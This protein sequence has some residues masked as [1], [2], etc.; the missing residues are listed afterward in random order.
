AVPARLTAAL[1]ASEDE[2][3]FGAWRSVLC[4]TWTSVL[5]LGAPASA[6][7]LVDVEI[8][9]GRERGVLNPSRDELLQLGSVR[10]QLSHGEAKGLHQRT[11][12]LSVLEVVNEGWL[13]T[14]R[15]DDGLRS[16]V[17]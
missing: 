13:A 16:P 14:G 17:D 12:E 5:T 2:S 7:D 8:M 3:A 4:S 6:A 11:H 9:K 1:R 10:P 15:I